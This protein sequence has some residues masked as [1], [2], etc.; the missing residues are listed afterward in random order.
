M[1]SK[2]DGRGRG[3][4]RRSQREIARSV[5]GQ[6]TVDPTEAGS[7]DAEDVFCQFQHLLVAEPRDDKTDRPS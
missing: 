4:D 7:R 3:S 2:A 6:R 5:V 1:I